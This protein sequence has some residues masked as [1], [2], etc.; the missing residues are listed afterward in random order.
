[1]EDFIDAKSPKAKG[2]RITTLEVSAINDITP[3]PDPEP[4]EASENPD[5]NKETPTAA[6]VPSVLDVPIEIDASVPESS[7]PVDDQ[8]S[9]F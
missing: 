2:K 1:M 4:E 3:E 8:L 7:K 5:E 9:L 6:D